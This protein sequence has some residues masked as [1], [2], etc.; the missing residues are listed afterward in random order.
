MTSGEAAFQTEPRIGGV[1]VELDLGNGMQFRLKSLLF[2]VTIAAIGL[3]VWLWL[4][5]RRLHR[6]ARQ[7]S[8]RELSGKVG[9]L[10]EGIRLRLLEM[11]EVMTD[12]QASRPVDPTTASTIKSLGNLRFT[13]SFSS[14]D[15]SISIGSEATERTPRGR[16]IACVLL[17]TNSPASR[18]LSN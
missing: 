8:F 14:S 15:K 2:Q 17:W 6:E 10:D 12:L 4:E 11:P 1:T 7:N 3:G 13:G 5:S 16:R 9:Q 18:T